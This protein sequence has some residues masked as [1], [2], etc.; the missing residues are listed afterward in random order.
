MSSELEGLKAKVAAMENQIR[1]LTAEVAANPRSRQWFKPA[2]FGGYKEKLKVVVGERFDTTTYSLQVMY[3]E[4]LCETG[5]E[6]DWVTIENGYT[7]DCYGY[8][9]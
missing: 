7:Y 6:Y 8:A 2:Y 3:R 5:Y 9:T 1:N 4:I